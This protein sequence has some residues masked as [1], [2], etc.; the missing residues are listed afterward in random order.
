[1][2][3]RRKDLREPVDE[4]AYIFGDG[5]S[6]EC[7]VVDLSANGAAIEARDAR[8]L[9]PRF[10]LMI[11]RDR[12]EKVCRIVWISGNKVGLSFGDETS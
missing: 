8:F 2:V 6:I 7:R 9:P 11:A 4:I 10:K 1:M 12:A 3:E 5:L